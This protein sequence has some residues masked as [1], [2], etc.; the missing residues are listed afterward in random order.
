MLKL[1]NFN[2]LGHHPAG[3]PTKVGRGTRKGQSQLL[4]IL[5]NIVLV[6]IL[7]DKRDLN[8]LLKKKWYRVPLFYA[9]KRR[10]DYIAFYQ[11][12]S[13][14]ET[15]GCINYYA[16]IRNCEIVKRK[17]LLPYEYDH[18]Y[19]D[20][21]YYKIKF[22]R[23][24]KLS[25]PILNKNR[26]R[27]SFG[28][29]TLGKLFSAKDIVELFDVQPLEK[30]VCLAL[31]KRNMKVSREHIFYLTNGKRYRLDFAIF[32]KK[33]YLNIECDSEKWHSQKSQI[34]KDIIRDRELKKE[35][36]TILRLNE[37]EIIK[38]IKKCIDKVEENIKKLGGGER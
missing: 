11:P 17:N 2:N 38:N 4:T 37:R 29:T 19:T 27:I 36:W 5:K 18:P 32:C 1:R 14:G 26:M 3:A 21:N 35:G 16:K 15:G 9:P 13:F 31:K 6:G 23:I 10:A 28:F 8:I 20:E 24:K 34:H 25:N 12:T 7:K 22:S 33:G 30:I